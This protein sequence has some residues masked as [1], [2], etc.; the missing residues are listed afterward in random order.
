MVND[1]NY[2]TLFEGWGI[3][4]EGYGGGTTNHAWSGGALTILSQYLCG[5]EPLKPGYELF[6]IVP[7]PGSIKSASATVESVKG[8]IKSRFEMSENKFLLDVAVPVST[9]AIVGIP[10]KITSVLK[11][12]DITI[13]GKGALI[14][15]KIVKAVTKAEDGTLLF[16]VPQGEYNFESISS[17]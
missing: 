4:N 6:Q 17:N 5:I 3:G 12:N 11:V 1:T 14:K 13:W 9:E 7:K 8:T 15:N 2:T 10:E 16:K